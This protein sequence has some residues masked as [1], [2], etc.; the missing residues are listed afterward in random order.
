MLAAKGRILLLKND[1]VA[2]DPN[3]PLLQAA[4]KIIL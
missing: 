3:N 1:D 4:T 2:S